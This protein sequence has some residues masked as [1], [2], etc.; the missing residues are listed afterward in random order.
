MGHWCSWMKLRSG[1]WWSQMTRTGTQLSQRNWRFVELA[2]T[3]DIR[4][5]QPWRT[6]CWLD[7]ETYHWWPIYFL[8]I[9]YIYHWYW[10]VWYPVSGYRVLEVLHNCYPYIA[11]YFL[12]NYSVSICLLVNPTIFS[13]TVVTT[14]EFSVVYVGLKAHITNLFLLNLIIPLLAWTLKSYSWCES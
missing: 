1:T 5:Y 2:R 4:Y 13:S 6:P 7:F 14:L 10:N 12:A 3:L 11:V 9:A 8:S